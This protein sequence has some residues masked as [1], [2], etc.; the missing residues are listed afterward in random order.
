MIQQIHKTDHP[1]R[2]ASLSSSSA[3][4]RGLSTAQDLS[5]LPPQ[6]ELCN[7]CATLWSQSSCCLSRSIALRTCIWHWRPS[8]FPF[9][10]DT[11]CQK[12]PIYYLKFIA[13]WALS[14]PTATVDSFGG[15]LA[16]RFWLGFFG[17][18]ALANGGATIGD[19]YS[20]IYIPYGL[21]WWVFSAWG[22]PAFG[23]LIGGFAAMV[24]G[25]RWPMWEVVWM[26][27]PVLLMLLFLMPETS[28]SNILLRRARRLRKLA[29]DSRLQSQ[30][31][32]DQRHLSASNILFSALIRPMEIMLKDPSSVLLLTNSVVRSQRAIDFSKSPHWLSCACRIGVWWKQ[33]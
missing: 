10:W 4:I 32:I 30:S 5:M 29:D 8:F 31:E 13:F 9:N 1:S 6:L 23:P 2:K 7:T 24:K 19:M 14:F 25:W 17:S 21:S 22:G 3:F 20:L 28:A 18:P 27:S 15:L 26:A 16:L 33:L 11:Y 12:E